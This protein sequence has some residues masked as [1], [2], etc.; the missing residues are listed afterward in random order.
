MCLAVGRMSGDSCRLRPGVPTIMG[1]SGPSHDRLFANAPKARP[2]QLETYAQGVGLDVPA[3]EQCISSGTYQA[4][5]QSD[6]E[7]ATRVGVTGTSFTGNA[8]W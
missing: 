1:S 6:V 5:V 3:F 2:K 4:T 7:E 8:P